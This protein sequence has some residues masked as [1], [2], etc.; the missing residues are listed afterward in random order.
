[1][2][3]R[4]CIKIKAAIDDL[5]GEEMPMFVASHIS[6]CS[7]CCSYADKLSQLR[8]LIRDSHRVT[9]PDDFDARLRQRL[10]H[11]SSQTR[12]IWSFIPTPALAAAAVFVIAASITYSLIRQHSVNTQTG[13]PGET[14]SAVTPASSAT[15]PS[16]DSGLALAT[17][18][19]PSH[20]NEVENVRKKPA[21]LEPRAISTRSVAE[22]PGVTIL[23]RDGQKGEQV[24]RVPQVIIG[25]KP[26]MPRDSLNRRVQYEPSVF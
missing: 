25:S 26:V 5:M 13:K 15:Q 10:Q 23:L 4:D 3:E 7:E 1:M 9:A 19:Q 6:S 12:S 2:K 24:M 21:V 17:A 11:R 18:A 22:V 14:A 16:S 8:N 20:T